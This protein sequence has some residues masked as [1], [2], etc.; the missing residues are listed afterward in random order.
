MQ[1]RS[2]VNHGDCAKATDHIFYTVSDKSHYQNFTAPF[3]IPDS[4]EWVRLEDIIRVKSGESCNQKIDFQF[5][6]ETG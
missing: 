2:R 3:P 6:E 1:W 4:W 5:M